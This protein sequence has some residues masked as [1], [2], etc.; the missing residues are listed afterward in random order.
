[1]K[2][3]LIRAAAASLECRVED[4]QKHED[5]EENSAVLKVDHEFGRLCCWQRWLL[6]LLTLRHFLAVILDHGVFFSLEFFGDFEKEG[7]KKCQDQ[8]TKIGKIA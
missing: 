2:L 1:M 4:A 7:L 3:L 8:M 6:L 5:S